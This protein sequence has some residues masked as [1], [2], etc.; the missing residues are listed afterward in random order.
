MISWSANNNFVLLRGD[1]SNPGLPLKGNNGEKQNGLPE[2]Q[3]LN[4]PATEDSSATVAVSRNK[5]FWASVTEKNQFEQICWPGKI[6]KKI[7]QKNMFG[8]WL[9]LA[10]F[11]WNELNSIKTIPA[12]KFYLNKHLVLKEL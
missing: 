10:L 8:K 5:I 7:Q 9:L 4:A 11:E 12:E 3:D 6:L 1:A 2:L